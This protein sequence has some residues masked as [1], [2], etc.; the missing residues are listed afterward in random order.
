MQSVKAAKYCFS[1]RNTFYRLQKK[2]NFQVCGSVADNKWDHSW[3][4]L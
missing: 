2:T 3:W 1:V 4:K